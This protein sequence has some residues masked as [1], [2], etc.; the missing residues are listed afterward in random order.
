VN[1]SAPV[2]WKLTTLGNEFRWSS[3]GTPKSTNGAFYDGGI[4]WA[5]IGDLTDGVV[6]STARTISEMGVT[7]S[8]A[9][10]VEAGSV[11]VAMY[12]SI[13]KLGITSSRLTTNQ[14]IAFTKPECCSAKYLFWYLSYARP[15]LIRRGKGGTQSNISQTVLKSFPFLLPPVAD[16]DR[17]VMEIEKQVTRLEVAVAALRRVEVNLK[18]YRASVLKAACEGSLVSTEAELA[19]T[20][21]RE[22][23]ESGDVLLARILTERRKSWR[24]RGIYKEPASAD[25]AKLTPLPAGWAW[26]TTQ[27]LVL[28]TRPC[29]YGV[30]QPGKDTPNGVPLV[31]VGDISNGKVELSGMKRIA[32]LIAARYPRTTLRGGELAITLVGTIGRTAIVPDSLAGGNTARAVGIVPL[33]KEVNAH[34]VEVWFRSPA[35]MAEMDSK[36][37][38]VA[39]KTLNLEDVRA[40]S[41]ALPPLAEQARIVA[42]VERRLSIVEKV[43]ALVSA[44]LQRTARLRQSILQKAFSG[45]L[46]H[47]GRVDGVADNTK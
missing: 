20:Q 40:A 22:K 33:T 32:G 15:E 43:E 34:W 24:G 45:R 36:S 21:D 16:Q 37:H 17:L 13:G 3:G 26:A 30:L 7:N 14:A 29:A 9:K 46:G 42:E 10:W 28:A 23:Y 44:N 25:A 39:R 2:G 31:R 27:Q 5:V 6:E 35:K 41:V 12:G 47:G 38:E 18:R 4:P 19:K 1:I 11:L 8:A